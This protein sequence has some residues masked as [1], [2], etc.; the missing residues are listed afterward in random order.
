MK[1]LIEKVIEVA[2]SE[3][4]RKKQDDNVIQL[5]QTQTKNTSKTPAKKQSDCCF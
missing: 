5:N 2:K 4:V 3:N 1:F